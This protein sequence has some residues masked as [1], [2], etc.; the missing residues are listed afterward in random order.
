MGVKD[1]IFDKIYDNNVVSELSLVLY[2]DSF[3]YGLWDVDNVLL[4]VGRHPMISLNN[5]IQIFNHNYNLDQVKVLVTQAP[6]VHLP[7]DQYN[8]K[9]FSTYF[10][11][12]YNLD[13][14]TTSE[15]LVDKFENQDIV[16]LYYLE[17]TTAEIISKLNTRTHYYHISTAMAKDCE[18]NKRGLLCSLAD[19]RLHF[20]YTTSSG[21]KF[22]NGYD[23]YYP[24]DYVYFMNLVMSKLKIELDNKI[25]VGGEKTGN[26]EIYNAVKQQY[27][28]LALVSPRLENNKLS[29]SH[30]SRY[31]NL[32]L[33]KICA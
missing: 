14:H 27:D 22:Y 3:F 30:Y 5:K 12:L 15:K 1:L 23:C 28:S 19:N 32:Y 8:K 20:S 6:Y 25:S 18:D 2:S 4:K 17:S 33:T 21:Y 26:Q 7:Q 31:L 16:T 10:K 9:H 11:G 24:S 29:L 13:R